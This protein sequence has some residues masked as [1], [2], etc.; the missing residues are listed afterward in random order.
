MQGGRGVKIVIFM[1]LRCKVMENRQGFSHR[2][3]DAKS[4]LD[5][6]FRRGMGGAAGVRMA[7]VAAVRAVDGNGPAV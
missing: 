4:L 5:E 2:E 1:A 3:A 7:M 6:A